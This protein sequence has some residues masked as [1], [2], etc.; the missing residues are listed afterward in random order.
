MFH[1][2]LYVVLNSWS[3]VAFHAIQFAPES[4]TRASQYPKSVKSEKSRL[5]SYAKVATRT[6]WRNWR[7]P[8]CPIRISHGDLSLPLNLVFVRIIVHLGK[9]SAQTFI[10]APFLPRQRAPLEINRC[11]LVRPFPHPVS[12]VLIPDTVSERSS[13][14][15]DKYL[16]RQRADH[17]EIFFFSKWNCS[18][19]RLRPSCRPAQPLHSAPDALVAQRLAELSEHVVLCSASK[20]LSH[21]LSVLVLCERAPKGS[22][23]VMLVRA[24]SG[25]EEC[26]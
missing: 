17:L 20:V 5:E 19:R 4:K 25:S 12:G 14:L 24:F 13:G 2:F 11:V 7:K 21:F 9:N 23:A 22:S 15:V 6:F 26:K 3:I 18:R 8:V 10:D 16:K 1:C